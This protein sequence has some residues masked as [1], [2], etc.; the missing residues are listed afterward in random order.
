MKSGQNLISF[1]SVIGARLRGMRLIE[2]IAYVLAI[3]FFALSGLVILAIPFPAL[4][5]R[6]VIASVL[7]LTVAILIAVLIKFGRL[8]QPL[9]VAK[10]VDSKAGFK[11]EITSALFFTL[12]PRSSKLE[13]D[14]ERS[15][16]QE[17]VSR[18]ETRVKT[19]DIS[20]VFPRVLPKTVKL[21]G[22]SLLVYLGVLWS[23][24]GVVVANKSSALPSVISGGINAPEAVEKQVAREI[25]AIEDIQ[26]ALETLENSDV[27]AVV[28]E[29]AIKKARDTIDKINMEAAATRE[30]LAQLAKVLMEQEGFE[31]IGK[32]LREG[33]LD[34]AIELLQEKQRELVALDGQESDIKAEDV[35]AAG[36]VNRDE[37]LSQAEMG[38]V[39]RNLMNEIGQ[40]DPRNI[41]RLIES[42]EQ[43]KQDMENQQSA[44]T[45]GA[46]MEEMGERIGAVQTS[47]ADL[48][49]RNSTSDQ[50]DTPTGMP[51]PDAGNNDMSGGSMFRKGSVTP[52]EK[53][54]GDDGS[55][56]GAPDGHMAALALEGRMTKRLDAVLKLEKTKVESEDKESDADLGWE[57]QSSKRGDAK[58]KISGEIQSGS[59]EKSDALEAEFVSIEQRNAMQKYFLKIH[60][61]KE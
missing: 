42:L 53:E 3:A 45:A 19:V 40:P 55:S 27:S 32:A 38:D 10:L 15:F 9:E 6:A 34:R 14:I 41:N 24:T 50:S 4:G 23:A 47:A 52:N 29:E 61:G 20:K 58:T 16:V 7:I 25:D 2:E 54:Q 13:S 33:N 21:A 12:D 59:Y 43:A 30:G 48:G 5:E 49:G 44:N 26:E 51:S 56:T 31:T 1:L 35:S 46:R 36:E 37:S 18:A 8:P 60:E 39:A 22:L 57:F 17:H 11:D 28:K